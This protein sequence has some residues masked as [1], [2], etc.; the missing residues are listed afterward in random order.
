MRSS[1]RCGAAFDDPKQER[2]RWAR[3]A[4]S[5]ALFRYGTID[6]IVFFRAENVV[7]NQRFVAIVD[8]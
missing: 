1:N 3:H 4:T 7:V 6:G 2:A 5:S 8:N